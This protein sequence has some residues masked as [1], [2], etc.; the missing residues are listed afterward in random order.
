MLYEVITYFYE[1]AS[2]SSFLFRL[3]GG[4]GKMRASDIQEVKSPPY[5]FY[6][7][8]YKNF[9]LTLG[10][11]PYSL[12]QGDPEINLRRIE[13]YGLV[14]AGYIM[15]G[16][17]IKGEANA[18]NTSS[19]G[20]V[21]TDWSALQVGAGAS[22]EY[23]INNNWRLFSDIMLT[24]TL[25]DDIDGVNRNPHNLL[26]NNDMYYSMQFGLKYVF[27]GIFNK[28]RNNFV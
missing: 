12:I 23:V 19:F 22:M 18:D 28:K 17:A 3:E 7:T 4:Y 11:N 15:G 13:I 26:L 16:S 9:G 8:D 6:E 5:K 21:S 24:V 20:Q 1:G 10:F 25:S 14:K 27:S 2:I